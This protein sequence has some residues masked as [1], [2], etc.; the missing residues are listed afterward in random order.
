MRSGRC[1]T[2][3]RASSARRCCS[4]SSTANSSAT[5]CTSAC[6]R[7]GCS[8]KTR[9][10]GK[11]TLVT[12]ALRAKGAC[13]DGEFYELGGQRFSVKDGQ[14]RLPDGTLAGSVLPMERRREKPARKGGRAAG[15]RAR[16]RLAQPREEF[17]AGRGDRQHRG[18]QNGRFCGA[19]A[20][21]CPCWL[22]SAG[23]AYIYKK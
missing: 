20:K 14:A 18:G 7:C 13:R 11:L 4:T 5:R 8:R 3:R 21:I 1:T 9:P 2:G 12:D 15:S 19:P 6:P 17:R 10:R 23:G 22:P 16:L